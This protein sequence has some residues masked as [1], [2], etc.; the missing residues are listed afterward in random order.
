[1]CLYREAN[2]LSRVVKVLLNTILQFYC[3]SYRL[4]SCFIDCF[5]ENLAYNVVASNSRGFYSVYSL[6]DIKEPIS[7]PLLL[8]LN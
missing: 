1:M 4:A 8:S 2:Y 3:F 6:G 7:S 5:S